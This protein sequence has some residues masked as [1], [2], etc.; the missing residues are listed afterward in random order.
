LIVNELI[1][2]SIKHGFP[3]WRKGKINIDFYLKNDHYEFAVKDNGIGFPED[4]N[5]QN[6]NSLG[7]QIVNS[8]TEQID[9]EIELNKGNGTEFKITFKELD[10]WKTCDFLMKFLG[11]SHNICAVHM[12]WIWS[13]GYQILKGYRRLVI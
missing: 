5:F 13:L 10:I 3:N 6:T 4:I 7:L 11:S 12:N 8:L 2:N 9:G 1:T